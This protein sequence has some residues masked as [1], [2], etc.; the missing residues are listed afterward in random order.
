MGIN[1]D[2]TVRDGRAE[3]GSGARLSAL[4]PG[5]RASAP[6]APASWS[7]KWGRGRRDSSGCHGD[8]AIAPGRP[9]AWPWHGFVPEKQQPS[10]YFQEATRQAERERR[11][12]RGREERETEISPPPPGSSNALR[13]DSGSDPLREL[14]LEASV[15]E[16]GGP[17][18]LWSQ[19][20]P[21]L[22][23]PPQEAG[24]N[25]ARG[26]GGGRRS[27]PGPHGSAAARDGLREATRGWSRQHPACSRPRPR[28]SL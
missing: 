21:G 7:E 6:R 13:S 8:D 10:C 19:A 11:T 1:S 14:F 27:C 28:S 20:T 24:A 25:P 17:G 9:S 22:G 15:L 23:P 5:A 26:L 12:G 3:A 16:R 18:M 4:Q 2:F